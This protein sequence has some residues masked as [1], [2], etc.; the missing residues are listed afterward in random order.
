MSTGNISYFL[1]FWRCFPSKDKIFIN[2]HILNNRF[3]TTNRHIFAHM[4]SYLDKQKHSILNWTF[5]IDNCFS[6]RM[7]S[8][9]VLETVALCLVLSF[10]V[11]DTIGWAVASSAAFW[12]SHGGCLPARTEQTETLFCKNI[13]NK[14]DE[15]FI[16]GMNSRTY[17]KIRSSPIFRIVGTSLRAK[18]LISF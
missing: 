17:S 7:R 6:K 1:V 10:V 3:P 2:K 14:N 5:L 18:I 16:F 11:S 13:Q 8:S 9:T 4:L 15:R 12:A